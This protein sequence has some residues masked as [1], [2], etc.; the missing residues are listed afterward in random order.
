MDDDT[1]T[2]LATLGDWKFA[3]PDRYVELVTY[4][5]PGEYGYIY[6]IYENP[7]GF[8]IILIY[9]RSVTTLDVYVDYYRSPEVEYGEVCFTELNVDGIWLGFWKTRIGHRSAS[10]GWIQTAD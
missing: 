8:E 6:R 1:A 4:G 7:D 2:A 10:H 9:E 3:L 5:A